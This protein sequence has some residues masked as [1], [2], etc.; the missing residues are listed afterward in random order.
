MAYLAR[1]LE[2]TE[3]DAALALAAYNGGH[4]I[5]EKSWESW[6]AETQRY[7]R[8]GGGIYADASNGLTESPTL[9][10]WLAAGGNSLC[11]QA[12]AQLGLQP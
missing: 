3:N 1:G 2:L 7:Y 12:A 8:W 5:I 6:P 11:V 4:G 10:E 9:Q